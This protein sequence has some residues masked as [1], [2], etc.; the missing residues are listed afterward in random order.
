[1]K[2]LEN[3]AEAHKDMKIIKITVSDRRN[4]KVITESESKR[5]RDVQFIRAGGDRYAL[6]S[7]KE[8]EQRLSDQTS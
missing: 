6:E 3:I 7:W 2:K 8:N 5:M 4:I 1:M